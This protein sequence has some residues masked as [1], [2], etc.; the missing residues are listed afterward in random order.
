VVSA[1]G[2]T[3]AITAL[4]VTRDSLDAVAVSA[5]FLNAHGMI[6]VAVGPDGHA[7]SVNGEKVPIE[8]VI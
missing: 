6:T 2:L 7:I 5:T 1:F 3:E 8:R 4:H